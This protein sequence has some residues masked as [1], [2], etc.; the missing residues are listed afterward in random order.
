MTGM[1]LDWETIWEQ[2]DTWFFDCYLRSDG[3]TEWGEIK[4]EVQR[5]IE[6]QLRQQNA[7]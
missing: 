3:Q 7:A 4:E 2:M 5:V 6:A 1:C